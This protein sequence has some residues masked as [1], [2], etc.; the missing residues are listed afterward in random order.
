MK[1]HSYSVIVAL[2]KEDMANSLEEPDMFSEAV[3]AASVAYGTCLCENKEVRLFE[4]S[5]GSLHRVFQCLDCGRRV[6][7]PISKKLYPATPIEADMTL[8]ESMRDAN[9]ACRA[10]IHNHYDEYLLSDH[11]LEMR[12]KALTRDDNLCVDCGDTA[13]CVHHTTYKRLGFEWL[14]DLVSLCHECHKKRHH[15]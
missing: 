5:N 13:K 6:G 2:S 15:L 11:W 7:N 10:H 12:E 14:S 8:L 9:L 1:E 4:N 3:W